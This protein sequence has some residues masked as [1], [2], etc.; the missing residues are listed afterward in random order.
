MPQFTQ[1]SCSTNNFSVFQILTSYMLRA[2]NVM[3]FFYNHTQEFFLSSSES[4]LLIWHHTIYEHT[5]HNRREMRFFNANWIYKKN[6]TKEWQLIHKF[7]KTMS[8]G[9]NTFSRST[10]I[11]KLKFHMQ[12]RNETKKPTKYQISRFVR[13]MSGV[14]DLAKL[15]IALFSVF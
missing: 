1:P 10:S 9:K 14:E 12:K 7:F 3:I 13:G 8:K 6:S 15:M 5:N 4:L 2:D 11:F